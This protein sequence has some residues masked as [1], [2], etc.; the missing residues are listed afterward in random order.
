MLRGLLVLSF[1]VGAAQVTWAGCGD[2]PGDNQAVIDA[3]AAADSE[4]TAAGNGCANAENHGA[5][6]KCVAGVAKARSESDPQLLPTNCKGKVKRCA[7]KSTCG[8]P[9]AVRC[10]ITKNAVTKCKVTKDEA[11]CAA[12][13]GTSIGTGSCCSN[14]QPITTDACNASPSGAFLE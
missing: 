11:K 3:R 9:G 6:V 13:S 14:T 10:C 5:Y 1:L 4:C 2:N 8:K 7:A 12:K